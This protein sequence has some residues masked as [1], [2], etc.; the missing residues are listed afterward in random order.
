MLF[1]V[2]GP[3][4][5]SHNFRLLT[6]YQTIAISFSDPVFLMIDTPE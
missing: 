2:A 5:T 6:P 4:I 1:A 3:E